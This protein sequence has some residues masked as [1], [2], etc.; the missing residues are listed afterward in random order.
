VS[1]TGQLNVCY[2]KNNEKQSIAKSVGTE[3]IMLG[4][5]NRKNPW[6][7]HAA[8]GTMKTQNTTNK[9]LLFLSVCKI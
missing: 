5:S 3:L 8:F 9:C 6:T 4:R 1:L 7:N 2:Y